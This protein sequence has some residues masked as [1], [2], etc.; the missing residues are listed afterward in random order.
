MKKQIYIFFSI[1]LGILLSTIVYGLS[2]IFYTNLLIGDFQTYSLGLDW[3]GIYVVNYVLAVV[4]FV[5]GVV[6]GYYL[7][8][9]WWQI[10]YV[11]KRHWRFKKGPQIPNNLITADG[12]TV[13]LSRETKNHLLAHPDVLEFLKEAA[14]KIRM[15]EQGGIFEI[16]VNLGRVIG[17]SSLIGTAPISSGQK[18]FFAERFGR[19]YPSRVILNGKGEPCDYITF[20]IKFN[21]RENKYFLMTA[22]VG[23]PCPDEPFYLSDKASS[24][25]KEALV[26][27]SRHAL[28]YNANT[29]GQ[30]FESTWEEVLKNKS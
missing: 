29:M 1:I 8:R 6:G 4:F 16:S 20:Q 27:W 24:A 2:E 7:G 13:Y 17:I 10:V 23:H 30:Y 19:K 25:F 18:T 9:R 3:R 5:A 15:S 21:E 26:F 28:V 12:E 14:G 22:Y 11:E